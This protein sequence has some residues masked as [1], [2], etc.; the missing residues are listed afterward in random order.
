MKLL[1]PLLAVGLLVVGLLVIVGCYE[2]GP[3]QAD[4]PDPALATSDPVND[5]DSDD[6]VPF[7][8]AYD[9]TFALV[10]GLV[11]IHGEG[12]AT[13]LCKSTFFSV[14]QPPDVPGDPATG[15]L[16]F[17][18]ENGNELETSIGSF[19]LPPDETGFFIFSGFWTV[20][21]GSGRF[22]NSTGGGTFEGSGSFATGS[23]EI[24]FE[25][26]ISSD[27][28]DSDCPGDDDSDS[29][30]H[31]LEEGFRFRSR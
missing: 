15:P 4:M 23:G 20:T 26:E 13:H 17:S 25:G 8:G 27:D 7:R 14:L 2:E 5:D 1:N 30:S 21:G 10:E 31:E 16:T 3:L 18:A 9:E 12:F 29:D 11:E 28:D 22:K 24:R 19:V 6:M